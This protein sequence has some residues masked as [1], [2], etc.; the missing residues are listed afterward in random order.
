MMCPSVVAGHG[1]PLEASIEFVG[2]Q[3]QNEVKLLRQL[4]HYRIRHNVNADIKL[5]IHQGDSYLTIAAQDS[6]GKTATFTKDLDSNEKSIA[7]QI[8]QCIFVK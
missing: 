5:V 7:K 6:L 3:P 2:K 4:K 1:L 8:W